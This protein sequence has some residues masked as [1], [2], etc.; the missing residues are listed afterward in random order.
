M[1]GNR[2]IGRRSA[3]Q[4]FFAGEQAWHAPEERGRQ[5]WLGVQKRAS[6]AEDALPSSHAAPS[7]A[8]LL[9]PHY[10]THPDALRVAA[11]CCFPP[12]GNSPALTKRSQRP[13]K[14]V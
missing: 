10:A 3:F 14:R 13:K 5:R 9:W 2:S 12:K 7:P 8:Q 6:A 1:P 4:P 11:S